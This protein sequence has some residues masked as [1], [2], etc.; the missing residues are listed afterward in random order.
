MYSPASFIAV[1]VVLPLL[2]VVAVGVRF[3][4]RLCLRSSRL[5]ADDYM[6]VIGCLLVCA[7]CVN[8]LVGKTRK[9]TQETTRSR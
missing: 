9:T 1:A 2:G 8:Q 6:I 3:Y 4:V 7:M 5:G